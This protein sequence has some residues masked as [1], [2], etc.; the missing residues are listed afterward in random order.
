MSQFA[1][2]DKPKA[3]VFRERIGDRE[4]ELREEKLDIFNDVVL[5]NGNPRLTPQIAEDQTIASEEELE[6]YLRMTNG[7]GTLSKSI[8]DVGQMEA[9]YAWKRDDQQKH[10]VIEGATRVTI[11]RELARKGPSYTDRFGT[12]MAK[13]LPPEFSVEE[14]TILLAKIHVRGTGVRSWGRYIEAKFIYESVTPAGPGQRPIMG[15]TDLARHMGKSLSWVSRLKDAYQFAQ[16]FVEHLDSP[17]AARQAVQHFSTLEEIAKASGV[18]PKVRDYGNP[19]HDGLRTEVFEMVQNEVFKEYRDARFMKQFHDDPE[20]WALLKQGERHVANRLAN[21]VRTGNASLRVKLE[22]L[23]SQLERA[24]DREPDSVTE[25]DVENLRKALRVAETAVHPGI[26]RLRL[27]LLAFK[28]AAEGASL[29]DIKSVQPDDMEGFEEA[30]EDFKT[31][32]NKH[33]TWK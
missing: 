8:A 30:I 2:D 26:N 29:D 28:K 4:Y 10:V 3:K 1:V 7:Y 25:D 27:E 6:S 17:D 16:K 18:G 14:R 24:I 31:R 12:V 11:L 20:K 9:I 33:K 5:W 15:M 13:V 32:L 21:E 23:P 22:A 19:E